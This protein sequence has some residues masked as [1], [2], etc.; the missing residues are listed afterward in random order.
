MRIPENEVGVHMSHCNQGHYVG[1]CKY[2]DFED[3]PA[4]NKQKS[5]DDV[6]IYRVYN[7]GEIKNETH[8]LKPHYVPCEG[9]KLGYD[10]D[11]SAWSEH[12]QTFRFGCAQIVFENG[13]YK[14]IYKGYLDDDQIEAAISELKELHNDRPRHSG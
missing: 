6:R 5:G 14:A 9:Q 7:C 8:V 11:V 1:S 13:E 4:L 10:G 3:C 12:N 2:G